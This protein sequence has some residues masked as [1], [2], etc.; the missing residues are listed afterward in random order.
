MIQTWV[1]WPQCL[2]SEVLHC[3]SY[4]I[5]PCQGCGIDSAECTDSTQHSAWH[6]AEAE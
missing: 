4:K 5:L 3:I 1:V 6:L 2:S